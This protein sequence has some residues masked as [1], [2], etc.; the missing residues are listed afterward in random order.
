MASE[1]FSMLSRPLYLKAFF[2]SFILPVRESLSC[3]GF[4]MA[5]TMLVDFCLGIYMLTC[6]FWFL[7]FWKLLLQVLLYWFKELYDFRL[8]W[9]ASLPQLFS[10]SLAQWRLMANKC[11]RSSVLRNHIVFTW[12]RWDNYVSQTLS[13]VKSC[14][15]S[16]KKNQEIF[17]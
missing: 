7:F 17:K 4:S 11:N 3:R 1:Y 5:L 12:S 14:G 8:I 13:G 10:S 16:N 2:V 6:S 9:V 15:L